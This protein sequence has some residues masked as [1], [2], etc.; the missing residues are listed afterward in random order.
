LILEIVVP[1]VALILCGYG[2]AQTRLMPQAGVDG[3][4]NFVI[5]VAV[6]GLLFRAGARLFD[7]G[8][9]DLD[10]W[11]AYFGG[12]AVVFTATQLLTG[13]WFRIG[14]GE[15]AL[16]GMGASYGNTVMLGIPLALSLYGER[17]VLLTSTII[18]INGMLYYSLVTACIELG[19]GKDAHPVVIVR[20]TVRALLTNPV[21]VP[22]LLGLAWGAARWPLPRVAE[23]F[24]DHL[25]AAVGPTALFALGGSMVQFRIAGD[26][27][28]VSIIVLMKMLLHPLVVW[29]LGVYVFELAPVTLGVATLIAALPTGVNT[30][31]LARQH[32]VAVARCGSAVLISTAVGIVTL[33]LVLAL[34]T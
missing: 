19:R 4:S 7:G 2:L 33:P 12:C 28:Q 9:I 22:M 20:Q 10:I 6:P 21:L 23:V 1:V 26:L 18:A 34:L 17:G 11:W 15:R 5:Y 29:L 8:A 13:R 24:L 30:F 25:G 3:I 32:E 27:H 14:L 16:A 31:M